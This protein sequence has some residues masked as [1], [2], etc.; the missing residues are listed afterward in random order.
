MLAAVWRT[1]SLIQQTFVKFLVSRDHAKCWINEE[2]T[3]ADLRE[4]SDNLGKASGEQ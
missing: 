2:N 1:S 4:G 3:E